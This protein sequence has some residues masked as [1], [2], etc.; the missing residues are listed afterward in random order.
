MSSTLVCC[1]SNI[2]KD[3]N[4]NVLDYSS[5]WTCYQN[6]VLGYVGENYQRFYF[7]IDSIKANSKDTL[8]YKVWGRYRI[9]DAINYYVGSIRIAEGFAK[10]PEKYSIVEDNP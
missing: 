3:N 2:H 9:K 5:V 4:L 8:Q 10:L 7:F 6:D 1:G